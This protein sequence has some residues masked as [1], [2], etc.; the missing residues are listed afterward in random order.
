[1]GCWPSYAGA[2][3]LQAE[4]SS[5]SILQR[6]MGQSGMHRVGCPLERKDAWAALSRQVEALT[7][8][9]DNISTITILLLVIMVRQGRLEIACEVCASVGNLPYLWQDRGELR[10]Q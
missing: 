2:G 5:T 1:M 8:A 7:A 3:R 4:I 6:R 9:A 10:T